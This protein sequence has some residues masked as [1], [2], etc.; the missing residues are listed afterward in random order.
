MLKLCHSR[1]FAWF[2]KEKIL[3]HNDTSDSILTLVVWICQDQ[4]KKK[5]KIKCHKRIT[6]KTYQKIRKI[7]KI[8]EKKGK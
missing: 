7:E 4:E 8:G 6:Y 2:L 1:N 5:G 3:K